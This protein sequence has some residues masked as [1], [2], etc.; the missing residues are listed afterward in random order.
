MRSWLHS[1]SL[2]CLWGH[3]KLPAAHHTQTNQT[4]CLRSYLRVQMLT[5]A[6]AACISSVCTYKLLHTC[7]CASMCLIPSWVHTTDPDSSVHDRLWRLWAGQLA[8]AGQLPGSFP[9]W[10]GPE[11]CHARAAALDAHAAAVQPLLRRLRF[12]CLQLCL[13]RSGLD[14]VPMMNSSCSLIWAYSAIGR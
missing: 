9:L 12:A 14:L 11:L 8:A 2:H 5:P 13:C 6:Y 4:A 3:V 1:A 7:K 10:K